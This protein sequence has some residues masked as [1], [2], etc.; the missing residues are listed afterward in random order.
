MFMTILDTMISQTLIF[1]IGTSA[2]ATERDLYVGRSI[3]PL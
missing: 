3:V 2:D 1:R